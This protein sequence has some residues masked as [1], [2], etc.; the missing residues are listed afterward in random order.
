[1]IEPL[2]ELFALPREPSRTTLLKYGPSVTPPSK[3]ACSDG[4]VFVAD[5]FG[6]WDALDSEV[7]LATPPRQLDTVYGIV[8]DICGLSFCK[9][10]SCAMY[11]LEAK[12]E[13]ALVPAMGNA[14]AR[15]AGVFRLLEAVPDIQGFRSVPCPADIA[16]Y[17]AGL[18][19]LVGWTEL[20]SYVLAGN[21]AIGELDAYLELAAFPGPDNSTL[22]IF[23]LVA[24]T[25]T[26]AYSVHKDRDA[27]KKQRLSGS[28]PPLTLR[29]SA[30]DSGERIGEWRVDPRVHAIC[31]DERGAVIL[32]GD[33]AIRLHIGRA[34]LVSAGIG[35]LVL[36]GVS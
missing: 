27:E 25:S 24:S 6:R 35:A 12:P 17:D 18:L 26:R 21:P 32:A 22:P 3:V 13:R 15:K 10:G 1:M 29:A 28:M 5:G 8:C 16:A 7:N 20:R 34:G 14:T 33:E 30:L 19:C 36:A 31:A 2:I 4:F 11:A 23:D 9:T